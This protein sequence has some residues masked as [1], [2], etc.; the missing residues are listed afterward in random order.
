MNTAN[1]CPKCKEDIQPG[2]KKCK[3]C[4]ADLRNWFVKHKIVTG[5]LVFFGIAII[6][7]A[8]NNPDSSNVSENSASTGN[9]QAEK[10][11]EAPI[12]ITAV[13]LADAYEKNEVKADKDYKGKSLEITGT[14]KEIG[15]VLSQTFV[16]L[17]SGKEF[18][19]TDIQCFFDNQAEIDKIAELTKGNQVTV[20]G[21]VDGKSLNVSVRGCILK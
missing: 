21:K 3:H 12:S 1:K 16:V 11:T 14:I 2:A 9:L 4:Q 13:E 6:A 7:S 5:I 10:V 17:S 18:S 15:T 8:F 19:I 20:Q